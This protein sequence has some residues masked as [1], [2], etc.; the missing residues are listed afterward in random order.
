MVSYVSPFASR[1]EGSCSLRFVLQSFG[2]SSQSSHPLRRFPKVP[3]EFSLSLSGEERWLKRAVHG[4]S[5]GVLRFRLLWVAACGW[6]I[7]SWGKLLQLQ[8]AAQHQLPF[9]ERSKLDV[10]G[11]VGP[12]VLELPREKAANKN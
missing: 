8:T 10:G 12:S 5:G 1:L 9:S 6:A 2:R 7:G 11:P 3:H 4:E